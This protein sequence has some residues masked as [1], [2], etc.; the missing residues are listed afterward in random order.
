[1]TFP[2]PHLPIEEMSTT[3]VIFW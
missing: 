2:I 3:K 1:M